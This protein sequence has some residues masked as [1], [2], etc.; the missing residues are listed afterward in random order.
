M[1]KFLTN[2]NILLASAAGILLI[3]GIAVQAFADDRS[4]DD[5]SGDNR[6][7]SGGHALTLDAMLERVGDHFDEIDADGDGL[8]TLAEA[9]A[10]KS[11]KQEQMGD[12]MNTR[13]TSLFERMDT[14]GDGI[15]SEG[16][17]G[18][19]RLSDRLD[20][21]GDLTLEQIQTAATQKAADRMANRELEMGDRVPTYPWARADALAD[22]QARFTEADTDGDGVLSR[23]EK[24]D[25]GFG[26]GGRGHGDGDRG[27]KGRGGRG[28]GDGNRG[29]GDR[30]GKGQGDRS[31]R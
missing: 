24:P 2:R 14:D 16:D 31:D 1:T 12:H 15:V 10:A 29:D 17:H 22:A 21:E 28:Y 18:Y 7:G 19:G 8:V 27:G 23:A 5:R 4:G 3:G 11:A 30:G 26:F 9:E 13:L 25:H 20:L 6:H